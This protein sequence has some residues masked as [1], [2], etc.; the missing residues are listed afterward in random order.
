MGS[1][2]E[3]FEMIYDAIQVGC[4]GISIGRNVFQAENPTLLVKKSSK[5]A[6]LFILKMRNC[7]RERK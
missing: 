7:T 2:H 5:N 3:L 1:E 6:P 4:G